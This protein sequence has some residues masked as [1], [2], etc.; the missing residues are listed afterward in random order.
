MSES[1]KILAV[2]DPTILPRGLSR[3]P[4]PFWV[5]I[6]A[7][8][9]LV[10]L[11]GFAAHGFAEN[12]LRLGS[13]LAWRFAC[14]AFFAA[15]IVGPASRLI[16]WDWA[17]RLGKDRHQ[18]IWGFCASFGVFIATLI[19][20]N[21]LAPASVDHEGLTFGMALF[22]IFGGVLTAV[23]AYV[24]LPRPALGEQARKAMLGVGMAYFWLAY[25]LTGLS[26]LSG[27][28]RPDAF[29]DISLVLMLMA[30]LLRFADRF[31][32]KI[33]QPKIIPQN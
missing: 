30:V 21:T 11:A 12:G 26:H 6:L 23:I 9:V 16:A 5:A 33:R 29:Y 8:A 4:F 1:G 19:V 28:H 20:P 10:S 7:V 27:P 22:A 17:R 2:D 3:M 32:M 13:Q 24:A 25:T 18:M 14:F 15:L 31:V